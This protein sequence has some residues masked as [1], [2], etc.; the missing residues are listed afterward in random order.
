[1][2]F[3]VFTFWRSLK[4]KQQLKTDNTELAVAI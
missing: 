2:Y 1:M 3:E 4:K